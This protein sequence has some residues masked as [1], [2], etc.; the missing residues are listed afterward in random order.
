M[1]LIQKY[2]RQTGRT[3][4]LLMETIDYA[5]QN[6]NTR[7]VFVTHNH[8]F[9]RACYWKA[10]K[11]LTEFFGD[12]LKS[13]EMKLHLPNGSEIFFRSDAHEQD[14]LPDEYEDVHFRRYDH[15]I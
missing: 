4:M 5:V 14:R 10:L 2:P 9:A 8:A 11:T 15:V 6:E 3:S 13:S 7:S 12:S 1:D